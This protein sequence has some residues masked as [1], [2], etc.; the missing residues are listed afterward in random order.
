V[1]HR[2]RIPPVRA[3]QPADPPPAPVYFF[4]PQPYPL[5][6]AQWNDG[7]PLI[8]RIVGWDSS[9]GKPPIPVVAFEHDGQTWLPIQADMATGMKES[10]PLWIRGTFDKAVEVAAAYVPPGKVGQ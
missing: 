7:K 8:G 9:P 2:R 4:Q 1:L 10:G 6:L 3:Q 5:F